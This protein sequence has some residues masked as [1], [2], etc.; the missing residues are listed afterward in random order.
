MMLSTQQR[1]AVTEMLAGTLILAAVGAGIRLAIP[2]SYSSSAAL[3]FPGSSGQSGAITGWAAGSSSQ[4]GGT[5]SPSGGSGA[6]QPSL[7]LMQGVLSVPQPGTSPATAGLILKSRQTTAELIRR[8]DLQSAWHTTFE[9][10]V[11]R[12]QDDLQCV[13]GTSGDLRIIYT[14]DSPERAQK[15][16]SAALSLLSTSVEKLSLNPADRNLEFLRDS[17]EKAKR[18]CDRAQSSVVKFQRA[19]GGAPPDSQVQTLG[20]TYSDIQKDL[21]RAQAD[22]EAAS[23][24]ERAA[25]T[26]SE[27]M[28][29]GAQDPNNSEK[30]LI[31]V[32]YSKV[33]TGESDLALLR[34]KFTDK[35][36]EVVL[37]RRQL[38][39]DKRSLA[40]EIDRQ[41][42]GIKSGASP[43]VS[44]PV[45]SSLVARARV[46]GLATAMARVRKQLEYLPSAQAEYGQLMSNLRDERTRLSLV[47][48]EFV[49]AQLIAQSRG[50]QFVVLDSPVVPRRPNGYGPWFYAM[51]GAIAGLLFTGGKWFVVGMKQ[52]MAHSD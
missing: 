3:L 28:V 46:D 37:A 43:F 33:V 17:L 44:Q 49:K 47:R 21:L 14:D 32:L 11:E 1:K 6:D 24:S 51:L 26:Q 2:R 42:Q 30:S 25:K 34:E 50:P 15:I 18:D 27:R 39:V 7:P 52:A 36:P 5:G 20:Q 13:A 22:A 10:S 12:L 4:E 29:R 9:R 19:T 45:V 40:K 16:T 48:S 38:E 35:R 31:S 23:A 8:F 41:V